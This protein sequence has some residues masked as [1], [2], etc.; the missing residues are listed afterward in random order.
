[1]LYIQQTIV[2]RDHIVLILVN[3]CIQNPEGNTIYLVDWKWGQ[4]TLMSCALYMWHGM[5][6]KMHL[7]WP[8]LIFPPTVRYTMPQIKCMR[9]HAHHAFRRFHT[10]PQAQHTVL[11]T[12][13]RPTWLQVWGEQKMLM[14]MTHP[15]WPCAL[16]VPL[17][18]QSSTMNIV[19]TWH[20]CRQ[21]AIAHASAIYL[22]KYFH[23][24]IYFI[25]WDTNLF[26][27]SYSN[28]RIVYLLNIC[29]T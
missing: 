9:R 25:S 3:L 19:C 16:C 26:S 24:I 2:I 4:M 13:P 22:H 14:M 7:F 10:L 12:M 1:M 23:I 18:F 21:I 15:L 6:G 20:T 5:G 17:C 29:L 27:S 8:Q 28:T 11:R